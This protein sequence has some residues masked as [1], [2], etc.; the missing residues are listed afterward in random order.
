MSL[1]GGPANKLGN[2]YEN[3]WTVWQLVRMLQGACESI[4]IEN[5]GVDKAEF[6][7]SVSGRQ[8]W[9]QAKRSY[10]S[11]RWTLA[12]LAGSDLELLQAVGTLLDGNADRFVFVSATDPREL[13]EL[14][15]RARQAATAEE[16]K[17]LFLATKEH[18][19]HFARLLKT[20]PGCDLQTAY[21]RLRRIDVRTVDERTIEDLSRSGIAAV[22]LGNPDDL[23]AALRT[24]A[25]DSIHAT[26]TRDE[27]IAQLAARGF[28]MRRAVSPDS[29]AFE[30]SARCVF[31]HRDGIP[32]IGVDHQY[33]VGSAP[34]G[35]TT[36]AG[37]TSSTSTT[38]SPKLV[39]SWASNVPCHNTTLDCF[40]VCL[41]HHLQPPH[42]H[43][44]S[45]GLGAS[46]GKYLCY[47]TCGK[48]TKIGAWWNHSV[49]G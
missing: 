19:N 26:I 21:N 28:A 22:Y 33:R 18:A 12:T 41:S 47:G 42:C 16:F 7:L 3:W 49:E 40:P 32:V 10:P 11:A 48:D 39:N 8:E 36:S 38:S 25:E 1:P 20:W 27:L 9:H 15:D 5:P 45:N 31:H 37:H 4:R 43:L 14:S 2:R 29:H 23:V 46:A 13:A 35:R 24:I 17:T 34:T 30:I 44:P 6:V